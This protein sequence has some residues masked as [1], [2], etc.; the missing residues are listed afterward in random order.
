MS[1]WSD[2]R[3]LEQKIADLKRNVVNKCAERIAA[4]RKKPKEPEKEEEPGITSRFKRDR[5]L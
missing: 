1:E 3:S 2:P 4:A 5:G